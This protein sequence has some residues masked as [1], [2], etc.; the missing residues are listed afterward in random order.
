M[1]IRRVVSAWIVVGALGCVPVLPAFQAD[2]TTKTVTKEAK[3]AKKETGEPASQAEPRVETAKK[4]ASTPAKS[5][6]DSDIAAAKASGKSG[7]I[8]TPAC[9]TKVANGTVRPS[10]VNSCR[11]RMPSRRD[12]AGQDK[13]TTRSR[14]IA[15]EQLLVMVNP[16]P[17]FL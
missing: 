10:K 16:A 8:R 4:A 15:L 7:S 13:M 12:T 9:I 11:S 6:S 5:V 2:D 1:R 14:G 17:E 3:K